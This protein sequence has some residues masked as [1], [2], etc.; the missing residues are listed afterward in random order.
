MMFAIEVIDPIASHDM[1]VMP[2][3]LDTFDVSVI[4]T[5]SVTEDRRNALRLV[6]EIQA[7]AG[8]RPVE[9]ALGPAPA[10]QAQP[11]VVP[12]AMWSHCDDERVVR[13][14]L[15]TV[16]I[17]IPDTRHIHSGTVRNR[18][19]VNFEVWDDSRLRYERGPNT[20]R[21]RQ[22]ANKTDDESES[23]HPDVYGRVGTRITGY[24][25]QRANMPDG[26][27]RQ[28][29]NFIVDRVK[30]RSDSCYMKHGKRPR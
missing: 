6:S 5:A 1:I 15:V 22:C 8:A 16:S 11:A 14:F 26:R 19:D 12:V 20:I 13:V 3:A 2:A 9:R 27:A 23:R 17:R 29:E 28:G 21:H 30:P 4:A 24:M 7:G 25:D 10:E 18:A